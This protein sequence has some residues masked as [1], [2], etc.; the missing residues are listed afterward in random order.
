MS[1]SCTL[2]S[3]RGIRSGAWRGKGGLRSEGRQVSLRKG[4]KSKESLFRGSRRKHG[5]V[6]GCKSSPGESAESWFHCKFGQT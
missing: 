6:S 2:A 1:E 3:E 4:K 5:R